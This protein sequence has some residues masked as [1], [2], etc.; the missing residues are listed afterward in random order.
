MDLAG[1]KQ[2]PLGVQTFEKII[3]G[4]ML[5]VDKT[6]A[7]YRLANGAGQYVFLSRPRRF[8][9]SLLTSTLRCYFEGRRDLFDGLAIA[10]LETR[11]TRHPVLH[12]DMSLGKHMDSARLEEYLGIQLAAY[13]GTYGITEPLAGSNNRLAM[14]IRR[15]YEHSGQKV[16]VLIDEYDAPLLD[17]V[18]ED[19]N[20]PLLR[21]MMRNFYSP[22]KACDPYLRF[23]FITGITK[24]SQIS[25]FSELNNITNVSMLPEFA[26]ICGF[27]K[28]ELTGVLSDYVE[29]MA[30]ALGI[31]HDKMIDE[32]T[33]RY[34][35]YHFTWPSPDIFNPFSLLN[36]FS[37]QRLDNFWFGSG[38]PTYL[39]EMM[40][41]FD[42][43]PSEI[44]DFYLRTEA[45]DAPTEQLTNI[46]PLLYQ[47][48]YLTIKDYNKDDLMYHI[49]IPNNE[50]RVGLMSVLFPQYLQSRTL[51]GDSTITRMNSLIR[52]D[53]MDDALKLFRDFMLTVP[54]CNDTNYEGHYQ[55][56]LYVIFSM[57]GYYVDV[58]VHTAKGRVD[59]ALRTAYDLYLIELKI[60]ASADEA[61]RQIDIR[62]YA[63]RFALL[64]LPVIKVGINFSTDERTI[65][66]WLIDDPRKA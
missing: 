21:N 37:Q 13:E 63:S 29:A 3:D 6:D 34:D 2:L 26:A 57:F 40:R 32:L 48:G 45:F 53:R 23:V 14:L 65:T 8:G 4:N 51:Q 59:M 49:D 46:V 50:I 44:G 47:S 15:A 17:V 60:N 25:I 19:E 58:E 36:A 1:L 12:F 33:Y 39:I 42:V 61:L 9:K 41:K 28:E 27:T 62:E 18:H 24:F 22:L 38:T 35:G 54:Y 30:H 52:R 56:M 55:Q 10:K 16:V 5:Y 43:A 11:W 20:L 66:E 31:S 64:Q 7:M